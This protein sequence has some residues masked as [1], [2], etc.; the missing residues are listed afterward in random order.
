MDLIQELNRMKPSVGEKYFFSLLN[1][2]SWTD[3][4]MYL[5]L[6]L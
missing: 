2:L 5:S 4:I 1:D 3:E 6:Q